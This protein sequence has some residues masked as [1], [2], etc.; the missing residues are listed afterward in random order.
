MFKFNQSTSFLVVSVTGSS[1]SCW[2]S[3]QTKEE[4]DVEKSADPHGFHAPNTSEGEWHEKGSFH[5][6]RQMFQCGLLNGSLLMGHGGAHA[7]T[8]PY[9]FSV[10]SI[11]QNNSRRPPIYPSE[12]VCEGITNITLHKQWAQRKLAA[13]LEVSKTMVHVGLL[14]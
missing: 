4:E 14:I 5:H 10:I 1:S 2:R 13:L 6:C 7:H 11:P 3:L 9:Y 12:F 8:W